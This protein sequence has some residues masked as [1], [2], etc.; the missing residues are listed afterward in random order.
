EFVPD[1]QPYSPGQKS[2]YVRRMFNSISRHYDFLNHFLSVGVDQYWRKRAIRISLL[3][4]GELFLD[5]AC[6]TGDLSIEA[7]KVTQTKI[8]AVDFA[9]NMLHGFS[10]KKS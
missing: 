8:V 6:G 10:T 3:G 7:A 9:E 4:T 1:K 2:A 5:I